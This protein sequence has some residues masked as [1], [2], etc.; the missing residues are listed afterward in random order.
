MLEGA[1]ERVQLRQQRPL[2][3]L[4]WLH[5]RQRSSK[6]REPDRGVH[7]DEHRSVLGLGWALARGK[8]EVGHGAAEGAKPALGG[9]AGELFLEQGEEEPGRIVDVQSRLGLPQHFVGDV[10]GDAQGLKDVCPWAAGR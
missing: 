5:P 9:M 3:R 2:W 10:D 4:Q 6:M 8:I 1:E 7:E